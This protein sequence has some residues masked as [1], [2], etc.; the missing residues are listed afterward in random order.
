MPVSERDLRGPSRE[1]WAL[2]SVAT[3]SRF[4]DV[5]QRWN[6][7]ATAHCDP[8][9]EI[10]WLVKALTER[11]RN[12]VAPNFELGVRPKESLRSSTSLLEAAAYR[13]IRLTEAA[14]LPLAVE[15]TSISGHMLKLASERLAICDPCLAIRL[16]L[17]VAR[18]DKD[19]ALM[20]VLSRERVA[21]LPRPLA[22]S[23]A[24]VTRGALCYAMSSIEEAG[25]KR[26]VL[27]AERARVLME[28][29]S[30]L[31]LRL[32]EGSAESLLA[33][34]VSLYISPAVASEIWLH[35]ALGN[36][37]NRCWESLSDSQRRARALDL[38]DAPIVGVDGPHTEWSGYPDPAQVVSEDGLPQR[39][40]DNEGRWQAVVERII[41]GLGIEG[42]ARERAA[43]RL[44]V[45]A[46]SGRLKEGESAR[47][48]RA[49][50]SDSTDE[51]RELPQGTPVFDFAFIRLPEP[52]VGVA[53]RVFGRKWISGD[54]GN[55]SVTGLAGSGSSVGLS[56]GHT[57]PRNADD[58]LW[59]VGLSLPFLRRHGG[60]LQLTAD[61]SE[62][63][64]AVIERWTN[65]NLKS[66]RRIP[67]LLQQRTY[68]VPARC[69]PGACR[70]FSPKWRCPRLLRKGYTTKFMS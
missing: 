69:L 22:E 40:A 67:E 44:V 7:L 18:Y 50:W 66:L 41:R 10:E 39:S 62:Y 33:D 54:V 53:R 29:A 55:V 8:S 35:E 31:V 13:S 19:E 42:M 27:W 28:G 51:G 17:R 32:D 23:L 45:L 24:T 47:V 5:R 30:R 4:D 16:M 59:Q 70:G 57:N 21:A 9:M 60:A 1:G 12:T 64:T 14:G 43:R 61:E 11:E 49:L 20:R 65:T 34:A 46:L 68:A 38:M 52:R 56:G 58:V 15:Y 2:W 63:L 37:F 48:A 26:N 6:K 36:T 3:F 25:P